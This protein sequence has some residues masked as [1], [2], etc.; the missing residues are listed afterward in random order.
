MNLKHALL[1][2]VSL[3]ALAVAGCEADEPV[4]EEETVVVEAE[5]PAAPTKGPTDV[6]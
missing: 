2:T 5:E 3:G 6:E 4:T 1:A